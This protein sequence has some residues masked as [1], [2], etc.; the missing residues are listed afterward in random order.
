MEVKCPCCKEI[1]NMS[2]WEED[3]EE[4]EVCGPM[5]GPACP[6]CSAIFTDCTG[7]YPIPVETED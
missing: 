7:D 4:C 6:N 5:D 2:E 3:S 1:S